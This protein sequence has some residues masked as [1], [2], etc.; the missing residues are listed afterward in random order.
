MPPPLQT[1]TSFSSRFAAPTAIQ[2]WQI[3]Y[4]KKHYKMRVKI[5]R[6][7]QSKVDHLLPGIKVSP[8][9][10][11]RRSKGKKRRRGKRKGSS[12]EQIKSSRGGWLFA[13]TP[14]DLDYIVPSIPIT[15]SLLS[16][17]PTPEL[18][19]KPPIG[20]R[21]RRAKF[22]KFVITT[23]QRPPIPEEVMSVP[24]YYDHTRNYYRYS[25][26]KKSPRQLKA[27]KREEL[28]LNKYTKDAARR[29]KYNNDTMNRKVDQ[30]KQ[31]FNETGK[32]TNYKLMK[33]LL[34]PI[35]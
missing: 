34:L 10:K 6:K 31:I 11:S 15:A 1:V 23:P 12:I 9:S 18:A 2:R 33:K 4:N 32:Q 35:P 22:R 14:N 25:K 27:L 17:P 20:N 16:S 13:M 7:E 28:K 8:P 21:K 29:R 19:P 24:I 5:A 3:N 26:R 30:K